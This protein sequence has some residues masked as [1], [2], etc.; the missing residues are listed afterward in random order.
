[1]EATKSRTLEVTV[2]SAEDLRVN[3]KLPTKNVYVVV[4]A[5]S[6]TSHTTAM[7][8]DCGGGFHS[9]NEKFLVNLA[10]HARSITF[11]VKCKTQMGVIKDVGVARIALSDFLGGFVPD[12][13][14]QFLS[15]RLRD[16]DGLRNGII[17]FSV[18]VVAPPAPEKIICG[19]CGLKTGV[20]DSSNGV[21]TGIP[22]GWNNRTNNETDILAYSIYQKEDAAAKEEELK[23]FE[24]ASELSLTTFTSLLIEFVAR[25]QNLVDSFEELGEK[26][27][28]WILSSNKHQ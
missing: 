25:L 28:L 2:L 26:A 20:N 6:I 3:G 22:I 12:N 10:T 24:S 5:E 8:A 15:Y 18:R 17:N 14:L 16:F 23:T 21:V 1:M 9:W 13:C 4:R 19:S 11:E 7:K 27:N